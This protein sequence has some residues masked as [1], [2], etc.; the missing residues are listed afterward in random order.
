MRKFTLILMC[1][2][3]TVFVFAQK[4][5]NQHALTTSDR[6]IVVKS[7]DVKAGGDTLYTEDFAGSLPDDWTSVD[8]SGEDMPWYWTNDSV[9]GNFSMSYIESPTADNGFMTMNADGYNTVPQFAHPDSGVMLDPPLNVDAYIQ[10]P[11]FDFSGENGIIFEFHQQYRYFTGMRYD[12]EVSNDYDPDNPGVAHWVSYQANIVVLIS[13]PCWDEHF[14]VNVSATA[15]GYSNVYFRMHAYGSSHYFWNVD[16]I[17][18]TVPYDNNMVLTETW[19]FYAWETEPPEGSALFSGYMQ[20][21]GFYESIPIKQ[22]QAFVGFRGAVHNYGVYDQTNVKMTTTVSHKETLDGE[23]EVIETFETDAIDVDAADIDSVYGAVDFTPGECGWYSLDMNVIMDNT[24]EFP[25]DQTDHWGF[26]VKD[27]VYARCPDSITTTA[28]TR[29]YINAGY[30]DD[31]IGTTFTLV[32]DTEVFGLKWYISKYN[33]DHY[34]E[35]ILEGD[36]TYFASMKRWDEEADDWS[37]SNIISS[38]IKCVQPE[39]TGVWLYT[40]FL[41]D[42]NIEFFEPGDYLAYLNTSTGH[43][44]GTNEDRY[45]FKIGAD[46]TIPQPGAISWVYRSYVGDWIWINANLSIKLIIGGDFCPDPNVVEDTKANPFANS[47][48]QNYPNPASENTLIKYRIDRPAEVTFEVYDITGKR[49]IFVDEGLQQS[50]RHELTVDVSVLNP[51]IY[52][53]TMNAG[54]HAQTKKMVIIK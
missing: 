21:G 40:E 33:T 54:H 36:Y 4:T 24:E 43:G 1:V 19:A 18:I 49:V 48:G 5:Q 10:T 50:G 11:V 23:M 20:H 3:F 51:G 7:M 35:E 32:E 37:L 47:L 53:Y 42:G 38:N 9:F 41:G 17:M 45:Y 12:I 22:V 8:L 30:D 2:T 26:V 46:L 29:R 13:E 25:E 52:Y 27:S 44:P 15:A 34:M 6:T 39:D 31:G 28:S 14:R 16:D